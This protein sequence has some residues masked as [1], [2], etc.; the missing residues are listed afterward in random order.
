[1]TNTKKPWSI[2]PANRWVFAVAG[3]RRHYWS[4]RKK[5]LPKAYGNRILPL[6][7]VASLEIAGS[8]GAAA[9]EC[10]W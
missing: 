3:K 6:H 2:K 5:H 8:V 4:P 1:M 10:V 7:A 9:G